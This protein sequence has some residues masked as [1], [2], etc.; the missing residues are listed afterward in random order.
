VKK[1]MTFYQRAIDS[2]LGFL[3]ELGD[4]ITLGAFRP[5]EQ[6]LR[7]DRLSSKVREGAFA[8][9]GRPEWPYE[10]PS[11][12]AQDIAMGRVPRKVTYEK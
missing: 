10:T 7:Y 3:D 4:L 9:G 6:E 8:V 1:I 11:R 2:V 5:T 12:A